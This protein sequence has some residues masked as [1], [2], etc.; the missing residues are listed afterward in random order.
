MSTPLSPDDENYLALLKGVKTKIRTSQAKARIAVNQQMI[1]LF[2]QIGRAILTQPE[3]TDFSHTLS[4]FLG[5]EATFN[6][7]ETLCF[8]PAN[9]LRIKAFAKAWPNET[10]VQETLGHLTWGHN[11]ALLEKLESPKK[12]LWYAQQSIQQGWDCNALIKHI[13]KGEQDT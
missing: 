6:F 12:R 3:T 8:S 2:W 11:I 7:S 10:I 4:E 9:L 5:K 1:L 13:E